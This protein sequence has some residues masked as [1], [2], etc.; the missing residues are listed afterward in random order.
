MP[1]VASTRYAQALADAVLDPKSQ[2]SPRQAVTELTAFEQMFLAS[3]EL[4]NVLLSP[5]VSASRKRAVVARFS[6]TMPLSPLVRNF[7]FVIIDRRRADI[8]DEVREALE[9]ELDRRLG[10]ARADISS[11]APLSPAQQRELEA[12]LSR[13]THRQ[14]RANYSVDP[15]L[16]GGVMARIGSTVYDGSVRARLE[17]LRSRLTSR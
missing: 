16:L 13:L 15:S 1:Q 8:L 9:H 6:E 12:E 7:I 2:L 5:A 17:G 11:A 10:V 4:R 14:I 3:D